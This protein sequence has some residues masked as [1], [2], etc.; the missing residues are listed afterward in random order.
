MEDVRQVVLVFHDRV[1]VL[2]GARYLVDHALVLAADDAF[3]LLGHV[4]FGEQFLGG[5]AAHPAAGTV[6]A[7]AEALGVAFA[8]DD[9]AAHAHAAGDDPKVA[10]AGADGA[11]AGYP[12]VGA[13]VV[14]AFDVVMVAVDDFARHFEGGQVAR[15]G[16]QHEIDHRLAVL[17][18][19]F[20]RPADGLDVV[21]EMLGSFGEV[22]QVLVG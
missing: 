17:E 12:D 11:L 6:R 5:G 1:D 3:G 21:V 19:V 20:L 7:G 14:F 8:A 15:Q 16:C 10:F 2:V 22:G 18:G 13:E 4:G 9:I